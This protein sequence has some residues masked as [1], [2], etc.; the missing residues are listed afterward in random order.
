MSVDVCVFIPF[1]HLLSSHCVSGKE[2]HQS[3]RL[4]L[5]DLEQYYHHFDDSNYSSS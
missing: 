3:I 5:L 2:D 1:H 4:D